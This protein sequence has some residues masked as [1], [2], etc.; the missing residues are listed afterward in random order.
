M[1]SQ[2]YAAPVVMIKMTKQNRRVTKRISQIRISEAWWR[3]PSTLSWGVLLHRT[4]AH[5]STSNGL[6]THIQSLSDHYNNINIT[7][8]WLA[9]LSFSYYLL[10]EDISKLRGLHQRA[11]SAELPP[12]RQKYARHVPQKLVVRDCGVVCKYMHCVTILYVMK[13]KR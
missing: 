6:V 1:T 3:T 2:N 13:M 12:P 10:S 11:E 9:K 4:F 5:K 8:L 7:V